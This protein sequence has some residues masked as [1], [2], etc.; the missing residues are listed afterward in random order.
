MHVQFGVAYCNVNNMSENVTNHSC[1][2]IMSHS[3]TVLCYY[4]MWHK[5]LDYMLYCVSCLYFTVHHLC[6]LF[7][8]FVFLCFYFV[9][10][11]FS[12]TGEKR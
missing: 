1:L 3:S 10:W 11:S 8:Q 5:L 7:S 6:L 2:D 4:C 9:H 12:S